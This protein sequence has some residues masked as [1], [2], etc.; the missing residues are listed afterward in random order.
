MATHPINEISQSIRSRVERR[1]GSLYPFD[2]IDASRTAHLVIDMQVA[3]L[4]P[5]FSDVSAARAIPTQINRISAALRKAG[6]KV[7]YVQHTVT[8]Q[9][10]ESWGNHFRNFSD[11]AAVK[12]MLSSLAPDSPG[13]A[14][15]GEMD[16]R[17]EDLKV[18]KTRYSAFVTGSSDLHEILAALDIDT[19]IVTG[20]VTN[21]CCESTAR[22]ASMMNYNV[23]FPSDASAAHTDEEHNAALATLSYIFADT[24]PT[25]ELLKLLE[26]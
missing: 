9:A 5:L 10:V 18:C 17:P 12:T 1:R 19:V 2:R 16:V 25:A 26:T 23:F 7:V 22:D 15:W 11:P 14:I 24:R 13:H 3:F 8:P 21:V 6:G 20:T 4:T